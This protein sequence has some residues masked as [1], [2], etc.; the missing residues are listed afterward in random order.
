MGTGWDCYEEK[1]YYHETVATLARTRGLPK[2]GLQTNKKDHVYYL[3]GLIT[4][5]VNYSNLGG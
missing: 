1:S 4:F 2:K 5:S 3:L